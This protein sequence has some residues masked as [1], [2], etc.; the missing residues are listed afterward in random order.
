M[1]DERTCSMYSCDEY[2]KGKHDYCF[3]HEFISYCESSP[4]CDVKAC[5]FIGCYMTASTD[6][7]YCRS[8]KCSKCTEPRVDKNGG[9]CELHRC[10]FI[11][12]YRSSRVRCSA[13]SSVE[14][15]YHHCEKHIY[16]KPHLPMTKGGY[17][18]CDVCTSTLIKSANKI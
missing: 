7:M 8:H 16:N 12:L 9:T 13:L 10:N 2:V 6:S 15:D 4:D 14:D 3:K 1:A 17:C 18:I 5:K 11:G